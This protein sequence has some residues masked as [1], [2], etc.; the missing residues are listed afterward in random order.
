MQAAEPEH[1]TEE[2]A[3]DP[4]RQAE[5]PDAQSESPDEPAA[6]TA[7]EVVAPGPDVALILQQ[8]QAIEPPR[9][10]IGAIAY[11]ILAVILPFIATWAYL[12][13]FASPQYTSSFRFVIHGGSA[14]N[15]SE[16]SEDGGS[17]QISAMPTASMAEI[18]VANFMISDYVASPQMVADLEAEFDLRAMFSDPG[19]D[20]FSRLDPDASPEVLAKYWTRRVSTNFDMLTGLN[21]VEVYA[22]SPEESYALA[23]AVMRLSETLVNSLGERPLRERVEFLTVQAEEASL[24]MDAARDR[25]REFRTTN[26]SFDPQSEAKLTDTLVGKLTDRYVNVTSQI[27]VLKS[28]LAD[29]APSILQLEEEARALA[30][31]IAKARRQIADSSAALNG[32]GTAASYAEQLQ[33]FEDLQLDLA[34]ATSNYQAAEAALIGVRKQASQKQF[35]VLTYVRPTVAIV[36]EYPDIPMTLAIAFFALMAFWLVSTIIAKTIRDHL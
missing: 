1:R 21:T 23:S 12:A 24:E 7:K 27:A 4:E 2:P 19:L 10:P 16:S 36:P 34:I 31:E 11:F 8:V 22:F 29:D 33:R 18:M 26:L 32:E 35:Y 14:T 6:E 5:K 3:P 30:D 13:F 9:R 17:S 28:Q 20:W 15:A 25:I